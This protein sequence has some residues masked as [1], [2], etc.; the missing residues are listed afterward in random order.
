MQRRIANRMW[1]AASCLLGL[2]LFGTLGYAEEITS[3]D[4][5]RPAQVESALDNHLLVLN[6]TS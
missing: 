4:L 6:A 5:P 2:A 1:N 3:A